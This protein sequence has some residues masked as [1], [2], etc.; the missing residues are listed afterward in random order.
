[1]VVN[2]E[3]YQ[4]EADSY[5]LLF[6]PPAELQGRINMFDSVSEVIDTASLYLGIP[7]CSGTP[8]RCSRCWRCSGTETPCA[9]LQLK[10]RGHP[11]EPGGR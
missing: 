11:R 6:K 10:G 5:A 2:R 8:S 3:R 4:G 1:M 7:L 9:H